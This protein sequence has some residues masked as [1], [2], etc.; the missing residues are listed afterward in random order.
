[1]NIERLVL[2]GLGTNCYI[3]YD[4]KTKEA[5]IFDPADNGERIADE[6]KKEGLNL[7]YIIITHAHC[8]HIIALDY[9]KEEFPNS[10]ICIGKHEAEALN[11]DY[12][13]LCVHFGVKAP[14]KKADILISEGDVLYLGSESLKFLHTPGH[15][16]GGMCAFT[17]EFV[18][19]GD[20][21]FFESVGRCDFPGGSMKE[22]VD[23]IKDKL[24][25][26][27]ETM[28][29]YPGHGDR[30]SIGHEK[31]NNPYIW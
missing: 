4:D 19:S 16:K 2:G 31:R 12:L 15:T 17:D 21:L 1:M 18:I 27:P 30:T 24:F 7:K 11:D 29:V 3:V 9:V 8:D 20:T 14:L 28:A 5:A 25:N 6:I 10:K 23:S 26:L 22:L 13:S